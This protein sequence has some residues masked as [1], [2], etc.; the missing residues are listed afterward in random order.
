M[1]ISLVGSKFLFYTQKIVDSN[2]T[3]ITHKNKTYM[4]YEQEIIQ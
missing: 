3:S 2:S 1:G 4:D